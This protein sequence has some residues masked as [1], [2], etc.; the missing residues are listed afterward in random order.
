MTHRD[1][2]DSSAGTGAA[3]APP[4][5]APAPAGPS[6]S[7]IFVSYNSAKTIAAAIGSIM[8]HLPGAEIVVVDN[9]SSDG[10]PQ[11]VRKSGVARL[12]EGHGNVGFGAGVNLGARAAHGRLLLVL[13]PDAAIAHAELERLEEIAAG[14][15]V[16]MLGCLL[17]DGAR[18]RHLRYR[19]WGW[20][21][22]LCWLMVQWFLVPREIDVRRRGSRAGGSRAWVSGTAFLVSREEFLKLG[23]FDE[24]IFLY[25]E[26]VDL[27]R[28]YRERGAVVGTTDA[29]VAVHE[30]QGSSQGDHE[31]VQGLALLS[32]LEVV[33]K[34]NGQQAAERATRAALR[35]LAAVAALGRG[36]GLVPVAGRRAA[37]KARSAA[38]VRSTFL[39]RAV[40]PPASGAYPR[41]RASLAAVLGTPET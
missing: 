6:L 27:S 41:A 37:V 13:N 4:P 39:G 16:G 40:A 19:E 32:F 11:I 30:G 24:Q 29:I 18:S 33:A 38:V 34:W 23:G 14:D 17:R 28:R 7:V 22:E 20:R 2:P 25:F 35:L 9:G 10:S 1:G 3:L 26:D 12:I 8:R 21:R 36:L 15:R 5:G 31:R